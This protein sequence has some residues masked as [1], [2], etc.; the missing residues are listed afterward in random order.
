MHLDINVD[1][2]EGFPFDESLLPWVSS[3][4]IACGGH[5]GNRT[6]MEETV[7]LC[8]KHR[9]RIGA[10]PSFP[11]RANFGRQPMAMDATELQLS[12]AQQIG[13]LEQ[14]CRSH[15]V[16]LH[17]VKPHGALYNLA[18]FDDELAGVLC[19]AIIAGKRPLTL[20]GLSGS[21][22]L[23]EAQRFGLPTLAEAFIDRRYQDDGTLVSRHQDNAILTEPNEIVTQLEHLAVMGQVQSQSGRLIPLRVDSLCLHGDDPEALNRAMLAHQYLTNLGFSIAC[24]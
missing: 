18:A 9:I 6:T 17:Y 5:A 3:A 12:L 14:I 13:H 4:S 8:V 21:R 11:D 19:R 16:A 24:D 15:Q 23:T 20:M 7:R 22:L 1:I 2:G 10:H